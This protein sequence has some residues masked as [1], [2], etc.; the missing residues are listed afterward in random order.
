[1]PHP[2]TP[3]PLT[4]RRPTLDDAA[5]WATLLNAIAAHDA[6]PEYYTTEDALDELEPMAE[7]L[8]ESA[9]VA[10]DG[11][12][13][14]G[15]SIPD[16]RPPAGSKEVYRFV[17]YGGVH[18][19]HRRRGI[20][21]RL[22]RSAVTDA[23]A[24]HV[25]RHPDMPYAIDVQ[26]PE[27][28]A[29]AAALYA[30]EGFE[31]VRYS[32]LMRHPLGAAIAPESAPEGMVFEGWSEANDVEF[33]AIRNEA[34]AD[35]WGSVPNTPEMWKA[36]VVNRSF[37]PGLS[38]LLRDEATGDAAGMLTTSCWEADT[39]ATGLREAHFGLIGTRRPFRR[40]GV[41]AA[42]I[43]RALR[44][45]AEEGYDHAA[46]SVDAANPS[47]AFGIY[48]RAGFSVTDTFVRW[49]RE[50]PERSE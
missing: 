31:P 16:Y 49:G 33:M 19:D 8:P 42:L 1:M 36:R 20:G 44:G 37:R 7:F 10:F 41:A 17:V 50:E 14:V 22:L 25:A 45:A 48:E 47:G 24:M 30:S 23:G 32:K 21:R 46:L 39:E 28:V 26:T 5:A 9:L 13:M 4:W 11:A 29:G 6:S 18:P 34:F 3:S 40:R 12:A 27:Q 38:F 15:Y 43:A 35:H 2:D